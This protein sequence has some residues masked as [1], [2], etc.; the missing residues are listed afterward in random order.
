MHLREEAI[1]IIN[2]KK[3][4]GLVQQEY[5]EGAMVAVVNLFHRR[6]GLLFDD[7]K[8][9]FAAGA[10]DVQKMDGALQT[11]DKIISALVQ[12]K[13]GRKNGGTSRSQ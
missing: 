6:Y 10:A 2:L 7:I 13:K 8:E 11:D 9:V 12:M 3:R 4:L 1:P 5:D